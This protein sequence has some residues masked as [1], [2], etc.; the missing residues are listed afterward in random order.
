LSFREFFYDIFYD[1]VKICFI[2][3]EEAYADESVVIYPDRL[4][5]AMLPTKINN[6]LCSRSPVLKIAAPEQ[7]FGD[8]RVIWN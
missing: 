6:S 5:D 4:G 2:G 7:D 1:I 3:L 8:S